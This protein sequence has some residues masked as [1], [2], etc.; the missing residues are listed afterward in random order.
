MLNTRRPVLAADIDAAVAG[1]ED[2]MSVAL[3][4]FTTS[5]RPAAL[6][7][8][9]VRRGV[10][11][12]TVLGGAA[13]GLDVDLLIGAGCVKRVIAPYV[14]AEA[15]APIGPFFRHAAEQGTVDVWECDE[16][17]YYAGLHAAAAQLPFAP[18]RSGVGTSIPELN[19][20]LR[21]FRDPLRGELLLAVPALRPDVALLHAGRA[22]AFG[23]VQHVGHA[24][25][26]RAAYRAATRTV[27]QVD[28]L[29]SNEQL[30]HAPEMTSLAGVDV[31]VR[32]P[33]GAH[34]FASP[35]H[36]LEDA[37]EIGAYVAAARTATQDGD[38][39]PF[40]EWL[41]ERVFEPRE[42]VAYLERIG[43]RQLLSLDEQGT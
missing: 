20:D 10:R 25:G 43:L 23:N 7:R 27:V 26:D 28:R 35:G 24:F 17:I 38:F 32:A 22:D 15:Y 33:Y 12:L 21:L 16:G 39:G 4:G 2:G 40:G 3:G 8:A 29:I 18:W 41:R 36:Y 30:R 11:N 13:A 14:G 42:H 6:V 9:L 34:P 37:T 1:V 19:P 31:V 5:G